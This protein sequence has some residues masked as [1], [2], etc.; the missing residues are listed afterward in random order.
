MNSIWEFIGNVAPALIFVIGGIGFLFT[1]R[2]QINEIMTRLMDVETELKKLVDVLIQ[3]GRHSERL[4]ALDAR[5]NVQSERINAL[6]VELRTKQS[7]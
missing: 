2:S 1:I 3:Q 7:V 4:N 6:D 5:L